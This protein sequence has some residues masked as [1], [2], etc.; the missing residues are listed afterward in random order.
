MI[1]A[2][3]AADL[4]KESDLTVETVKGGLGELSVDL[5]GSKVFEGSRLWYPTPGGVI[6]KVR[7]ALEK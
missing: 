3:V 7:A 1:A 6:K 4:S 5:D 2:R